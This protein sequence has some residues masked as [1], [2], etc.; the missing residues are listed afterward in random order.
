MLVLICWLDRGLCRSAQTMGQPSLEAVS[1]ALEDS[2]KRKTRR[3][4]GD[5]P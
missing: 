5:V 1:P 2:G 4:S 3:E